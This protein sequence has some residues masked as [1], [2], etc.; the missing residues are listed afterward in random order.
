M[1]NFSSKIKDQ[2]TKFKT[3]KIGTFLLQCCPT[4]KMCGN[5]TTGATRQSVIKILANSIKDFG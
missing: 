2:K 1:L 3:K 5:K 4:M